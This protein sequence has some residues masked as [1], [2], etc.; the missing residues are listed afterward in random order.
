MKQRPSIR[1]VARRAGLSHTA[2]SMALRG[3]P[4]ITA[5]TRRRV[6]S[7]AKELD[8]RP[9]A[10]VA[11]LMAQLRTIRSGRGGESLGI[12]TAWPT[13]DGW[14]ASPNHRRFFMGV[15]AR[16]CELSYAVNVFWLREPGMTSR[17]MSG[18]LRDC[19]IRGLI[20]PP[21]PKANG[22]LALE[23]RHFAVVTKGLTVARPRL[24]RVV[25]S[26]FEDMLL[27]GRHL[28]QLAYRRPGLVLGA[29]ADARV[30]H[31]WLAAY[32][33]YQ[34][35]LPIVD[36]MP[37]FIARGEQGAPEFIRWFS[38]HRPDVVLFTGQ[39]VPAWI[40]GQQVRVPEDVGL[41]NLDWSQDAGS[42]SGIDSHPEMLG[43]AAVDLLVGQLH[44]HEYG[45]PNYEKIMAVKGRWRTG[46]STRPQ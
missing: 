7:A 30:D 26:H 6:E 33:F 44:S 10:V 20:L 41:I 24:H 1:D 22:H 38:G 14:M 39:P 37:A 9:H 3:D 19:G 45:I 5:A 12:V 43:M 18:H 21:L 27:V 23:W 28:K 4:R 8:Y 13:Q 31:A 35:T 32:L 46:T 17:R 42:L 40:A 16:A 34:R 29:D 2:A 36:R 15:K 25:S 11:D